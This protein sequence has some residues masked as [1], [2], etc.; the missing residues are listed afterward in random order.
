MSLLD[1]YPAY[2][3]PTNAEILV[4]VM[5]WTLKLPLRKFFTP[6]IRRLS[7][8]ET[9]A[10]LLGVFIESYSI[11]STSYS[12]YRICI[13]FPVIRLYLITY[14]FQYQ[15]LVMLIYIH[16]SYKAM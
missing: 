4:P 8:S 2:Y 10:M 7:L 3:L 1:S 6:G 16:Y 12:S 9:L 15:K 14:L 5:N 13:H 11:N